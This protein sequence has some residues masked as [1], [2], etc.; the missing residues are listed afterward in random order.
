[1]LCFDLCLIV[2]LSRVTELQIAAAHDTAA[3][4]AALDAQEAAERIEVKTK[5]TINQ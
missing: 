4:Q 2:C 5:L 3:A 1:M